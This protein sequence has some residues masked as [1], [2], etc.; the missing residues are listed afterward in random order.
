MQPVPVAKAPQG[1]N[2]LAD[3]TQAQ[4]AW[5]CRRARD[6][7]PGL[8]LQ[9]VLV[10]DI[11]RQTVEELHCRVAADPGQVEYA[12]AVPERRRNPVR[13]IRRQ[14][15]DDAA[16]VEPHARIG[17]FEP[18]RRS[19]IEELQERRRQAGGGPPH[20]VDRACLV[21]FVDD[22]ERV[23]NACREHRLDRHARLGGGPAFLCSRDTERGRAGA[24]V[25]QP[26]RQAGGRGKAARPPR[27]SD[28]W[29]AGKD[30][31]REM[32][33]DTARAHEVP[34]VT[35]EEGRNLPHPWAFDMQLR[36]ESVHL[37][38]RSRSHQPTTG[39]RERGQLAEQ[40]VLDLSKTRFTQPAGMASFCQFA[41]RVQHIVA[42]HRVR[43]ELAF[44]PERKGAEHLDHLPV[45]G[46]DQ[47]ARQD[48]EFARIKVGHRATLPCLAERR[49]PLWQ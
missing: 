9:T 6:E 36:G 28:P 12:A 44:H 29:R 17:A 2:H 42:E 22:H 32:K 49:R 43:P 40:L 20:A 21:D 31:R 13:I 37:I 7:R 48:V 38:E 41:R 8:R 19:G 46:D 34:H 15:P 39:A 45:I 1:L 14:H 26:R 3:L 47:I 11:H 33:P 27:L 25:D 24:D 5:P 4:A 23:G 30:D 35:H 10:V 16:H 18:R